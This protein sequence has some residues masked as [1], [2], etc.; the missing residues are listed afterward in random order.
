MDEPAWCKAYCVTIKLPMF[1]VNSILQS[2]GLL[3]VAIIIFAESGILLG[4]FLPGDTLLVTAGLLASQ[5]KL[6]SIEWLVAVVIV[7]AILGYQVGYMFGERAGPKLFKRRTGILFRED[8]IKRTQGF[9]DKYGA[10]T[11]VLGRFVAH[12]RTFISV[13][14]GAAKMDKRRYFIYN[15]VGAI[16]WGG[17]LT[18]LGYWLGSAVP[19]VDHYFIPVIIVALIIF[20]TVAIW[21]FMKTPSRRH[22]LRKGLKEDWNY[23]FG[24]KKS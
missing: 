8:Y 19:N 11:V 5:G 23:F 12:V 2:G 9:F 20:Y 24:R 18:L 1:D 22:N 16:L 13:I 21:Q 7:S 6:H 10:L 14:A 3:A 15:V 17:G 4:F